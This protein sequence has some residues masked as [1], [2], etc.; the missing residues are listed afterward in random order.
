MGC[1]WRWGRS[2]G[3]LERKNF[4][5]G[6]YARCRRPWS[7]HK[8]SHGDRVSGIGRLPAIPGVRRWSKC[9]STGKEWMWITFGLPSAFVEQLPF[10]GSMITRVSIDPP[11]IW[12]AAAAIKTFEL[13][14]KSFVRILSTYLLLYSC[15]LK[16]PTLH[17]FLFHWTHRAPARPL[18]SVHQQQFQTFQ[19]SLKVDID[20]NYIS[21]IYFVPKEMNPYRV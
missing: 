16:P 4:T 11:S 19:N 17:V 10:G 1:Q 5:W 20:T 2:L 15:Q 14:F 6:G 21:C 13:I 9:A 7:S 8:A 18:N 12:E 3:F